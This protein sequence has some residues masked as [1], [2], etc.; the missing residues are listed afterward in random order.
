MSTV[1]L[2]IGLS[3][4]ATLAPLPL[5]ARR[6]F[7]SAVRAALRDAAATVYVDG[8]TSKGRWQDVATGLI[9]EETS[10]T[11]VADVPDVSAVRARLPYLA[12]TF[13]QDAIA[14]TVGTTE[15]AA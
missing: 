4:N 14:L 12:A 15:L 13:E 9:V 11:W 2:T 8:A 1:T 3:S 7:V 10:R 5:S 6:R